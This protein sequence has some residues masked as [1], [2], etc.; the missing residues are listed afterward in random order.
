MEE[1][2]ELLKN[3]YVNVRR[4]KDK[5]FC[6]DGEGYKYLLS[7]EAIKMSNTYKFQRYSKYNPYTIENI[8][9]YIKI[10]HK[11]TSLISE[12]YINANKSPL[13]FVCEKCGEIYPK[14]LYHFLESECCTCQKCSIKRAHEY[15]QHKTE[16]VKKTFESLELI[17]LFD[18]YNNIKELLPFENKE[19][20]RSVISY[21]SLNRYNK[22]K[23]RFFKWDNPYFIYNIKHYI[24]RNKLSCCLK[25]IDTNKK[26]LIMKCSC[27]K[28]FTVSLASFLRGQTRCTVCTKA[29]SSIM[30]LVEDWLNNNNIKYIKEFSFD[31]CV[32]KRKLRFDY[33]IKQDS[34]LK[35][36]EVDGIFHFTTTQK[37]DE[38]CL[39]N[40]KK[41]DEI[42]NKYC[43]NN[44]IPL[45]RLPYWTFRDGSYKKELAKFIYG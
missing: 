33:C 44:N 14:T 7:K 29:T 32:Y 18:K 4:I 9:H 2:K 10:M 16:Y 11:N 13:F 41:R 15:K 5:I 30:F 25:E 20:Y 26:H 39:L 24:V 19:G 42:K 27:G 8:R 36:I 35:L 21:L 45:L 22:L 23:T 1:I 17:P 6:A 3:G 37:T 34:N 38:E 43:K 12:E 31:D 28:I 40:Q